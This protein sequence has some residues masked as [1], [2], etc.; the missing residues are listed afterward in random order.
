MENVLPACPTCGRKM[1]YYSSDVFSEH[2]MCRNCDKFL[3][4]ERR[5][6]FFTKSPF[7]PRYPLIHD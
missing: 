4:V 5:T 1:I 3:A 2:Y 6:G 7:K